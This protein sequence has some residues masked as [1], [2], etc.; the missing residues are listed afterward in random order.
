MRGRADDWRAVVEVQE[1][2]TDGE[3]K[4]TEVWTAGEFSRR[5]DGQEVEKAI[6][7]YG[8]IPYVIVPNMTQPLRFWG[9]SDLEDI[10]TL[11][12]EL[13]VR[14]SVLSQLLQM[15]GNPVTGL[16][17]VD[18]ADNLRI[19]PGAV[20]TLP[21]GARASL[22]ELI[23]D[24]GVELHVRFIE[25][26][27][28]MLHDLSELPGSSFGETSKG[29]GGSSGTALEVMLQPMVQRIQRKRRIWENALDVRNR[30]MLALAGLPVHRSRIIWPDLLPKDRASLV[31]QEIGL[32]ASRLHSLDTA[33]RNL[34]DE[35]PELENAQLIREAQQLAALVEQFGKASFGAADS[36]TQ[37]VRLSGALLQGLSNT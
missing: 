14:V 3:K 17:N 15:S 9:L 28:K 29:I 10:A 25:L 33:R 32:V 4:I 19:G 1:S 7:P 13:N 37:P 5:V 12:S 8:F 11:G 26:L 31:T 20:W 2:Y 18:G 6:N 30:M 36:I 21:E 34:G 22:L 35:Q 16:E 24:G 23:K 27:Y